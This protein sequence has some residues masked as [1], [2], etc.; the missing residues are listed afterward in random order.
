[1]KTVGWLRKVKLRG[2][3]KIDWLVTFASAAFNLRRLTTLRP[4]TT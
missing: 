2:L 3:A 4:A 1:M